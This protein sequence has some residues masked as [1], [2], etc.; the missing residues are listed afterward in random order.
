M[1]LTISV[2]SSGNIISADLP[3]SLSVADFQAYLEAETDIDPEKQILIHNGKT[4]QK[5]KTLEDIGLKEDDLI[6]LKEKN[7]QA[8]VQTEQTDQDPVNHQVELLRSQYINNSQMNTHLRQ[9]DPGLH[10]KLNDPAAFKAVVLERLQQVQSSGMGSYR[11]PQQ[12]EE[13]Q[14]LQENPDDPENQARIMEMIRQERIDE[15]MQLAMDLT[16]ESFTSVNMLY[17]NIKVNGVKVQAFVDSGAQTTIISPSLAEKLGISRLIDR[18]FRGEA[19]GVGSQIIEGKIHS[20]PITIGESNVEIPCSFM[21]VDTPVDLL[22]GLD[23]LKRHGCVI[24]LQKNVMTVGGVI[25]TKFLHE[26]EIESDLTKPQLG[27]NR[28]GS[29]SG[30][31]GFGGNLFGNGEMPV[32]P[33]NAST[34]QPTESASKRHNSGQQLKQPLEDAIKQITALGF[35]RHEAIGALQSCNGNVEMAASLLYQ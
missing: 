12:Q 25:E 33:A 2:E 15:N 18:R 10:S 26:L 31:S 1:K 5:D 7:A 6:V 21:V 4:I 22:F 13:F 20:V 14:K 17:I 8:A 11:S 24:D 23:M 29:G 35:T 32:P 28:L 27:G 19:R 3:S 34:P 30:P 9:T 16:P